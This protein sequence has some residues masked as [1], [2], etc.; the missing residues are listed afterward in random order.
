MK[1]FLILPYDALVEE[2][3]LH[4]Y[5]V[6]SKVML[7]EDQA[8]IL[9][10][11]AIPEGKRRKPGTLELEDIPQPSADELFTEEIEALNANYDKAMLLLANE[12]HVAIARDGSVE[13][14]KVASVRAN[15]TALDSQY[16]TD[17][18]AIINKYYGA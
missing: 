3:I 12:Y 9:Y 15:I 11:N 6:E 13:T 2:R 4:M 18:L 8:N 14:E 16:E 17:Q 1:V 10:Y 5:S 7:T